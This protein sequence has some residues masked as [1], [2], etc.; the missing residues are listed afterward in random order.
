MEEQG[1]SSAPENIEENAIQA[2]TEPIIHGGTDEISSSYQ[3]TLSEDD[4]FRHFYKAVQDDDDDPVTVTSFGHQNFPNSTNLAASLPGGQRQTTSMPLKP[5]LSRRA[6]APVEP[7][8][9]RRKC[10]V[11]ECQNRVVQ[12]GLCI[13]H[14]AKRKT[15]NFPGCTKNVKKQGKCSAHGPE[16]KR[17]EAEG[18]TK[19]AVQG[20]RC[21]SHGAKKKGCCIEGCTK[22]SIIQG[23]C[24]KHHDEYCK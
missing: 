21:I 1:Y 11:A 23:M 18:C 12:G 5:V 20:G 3:R 24:K 22:Q 19:V 6:S 16:R 9:H 2:T 14:G 4:F 10:A 8:R 7:N 17:C 13:S 15:C